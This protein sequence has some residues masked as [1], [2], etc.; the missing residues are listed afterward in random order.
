MAIH[1]NRQGFQMQDFLRVKKPVDSES[2]EPLHLC[3][4]RIV[5]NNCAENW[6]LFWVCGNM[7]AVL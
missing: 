7:G 3:R 1:R 6:A 5:A 2:A 4:E